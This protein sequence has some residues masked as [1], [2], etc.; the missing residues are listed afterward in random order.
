MRLEQHNRRRAELLQEAPVAGGARSSE[1]PDLLIGDAAHPYAL[2]PRG[3]CPPGV[4]PD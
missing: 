1:D 2:A 3:S 4:K